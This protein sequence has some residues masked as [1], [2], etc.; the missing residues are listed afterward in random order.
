MRVVVDP[1]WTFEEALDAAWQAYNG[2]G[3]QF[4]AT[5][6][7][8][9]LEQWANVVGRERAE[10]ELAA[11]LKDGVDTGL[12][13][14]AVRKLKNSF[15]TM[16][17]GKRQARGDLF[18]FLRSLPTRD[19]PNERSLAAK[20]LPEFAEALGYAQD[21]LFY[22][23][24]LRGERGLRPDAV[25]ADTRLERPALVIET[26]IFAHRQARGWEG[27]VAQVRDYLNVSGAA[28]AILLTPQRL[29]VLS[30]GH[31][32]EDYDLTSITKAQTVIL[33]AKLG[34]SLKSRRH[35]QATLVVSDEAAPLDA[36]ALGA[37][38]EAVVN[39]SSND[40][41]KKTLERL[42]VRLVGGLDFVRCKY[43]NLVTKS[44]EIDIVGEY[45]GHPKP[46]LFDDYGRYF[47]VE[48]KNWKAPIDAKSVRDFLG[49]LQKIRARLGVIFSRNGIT[50]THA[51]T[52]GLR[53]LHSSFDRDGTAVLVVS[54][55]DLRDCANGQQFYDLLD[56]K[57]DRLRF[58][59]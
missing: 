4:G 20:A 25:I 41:K 10:A 45:L 13:A 17:R 6:R 23:P 28:H 26:K 37:M 36:D 5:N 8:R 46:T 30:A 19:F 47:L 34:G 42:A 15:S 54:E 12:S 16:P 1:A 24:A 29:Y 51:G 49:K 7:I 22:E 53:E 38:L 9:V 43:I 33:R 59:M 35:D 57:L 48:C 39:A 2:A 56:E 44:S 58:D 32:A 27:A 31:D 55:D 52:D 3:P 14:Y 40:E 18:A 11:A 50:G 21:H